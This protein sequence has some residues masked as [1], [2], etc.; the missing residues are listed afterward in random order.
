VDGDRLADAENDTDG[1]IVELEDEVRE[2]TK[3]VDPK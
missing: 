3:M 2:G 1:V